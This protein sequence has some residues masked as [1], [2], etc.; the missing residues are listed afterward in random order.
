MDEEK[1]TCVI[2]T[3]ADWDKAQRDARLAVRRIAAVSYVLLRRSQI[4]SDQVPTKLRE[5]FWEYS[6]DIIRKGSLKGLARM[7]RTSLRNRRTRD[8][9]RSLELLDLEAMWR[10]ST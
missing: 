2:A 4:P 7:K 8:T 5:L 9:L 10:A 3:Q 1:E 6:P